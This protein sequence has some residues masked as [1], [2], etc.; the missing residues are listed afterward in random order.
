MQLAVI[1]PERIV[2][3]EDV[4]QVTAP[5]TTGQITILPHHIG[6]LTKIEAGE[7]IIQKGENTR[8]LAVTD[9]FLEVEKDKIKVLVDYA[10]RA[11][12]VEAQQALEAQKRAEKKM[13]EAQERKSQ[14]DLVLAEGELRRAILELKV[15]KR[16]PAGRS[17]Q[18]TV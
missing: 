9:G 4:G 5:T 1:T 7:L 3:S 6:L 16:R 12:E 17:P 15:A 14:E 10:V 2:F 8:F 11:E 18:Q 13:K